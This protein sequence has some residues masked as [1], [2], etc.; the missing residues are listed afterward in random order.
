RVDAS[1]AKRHNAYAKAGLIRR[2]IDWLP[3]THPRQP[4]LVDISGYDVRGSIGL[5]SQ[6]RRGPN[7]GGR[8]QERDA[9]RLSHKRLIPCQNTRLI[10]EEIVNPAR[11]IP[12]KPTKSGLSPACAQAYRA[13]V[14]TNT[15]RYSAMS[16]PPSTCTCGAQPFEVNVCEKTE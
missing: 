8:R 15:L 11:S 4:P 9:R 13:S 16:A 6:H 10:P 3:A 7:E 2:F 14:I 1:F 5:L 12:L